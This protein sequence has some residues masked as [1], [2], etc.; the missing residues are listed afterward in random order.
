MDKQKVQV[1]ICGKQYV[2][3]TD[4]TP[5]HVRRVANY[6]DRIL[7]DTVA[8]TRLTDAQA[9]VLAAVTLAEEVLQCRDENARL[10]RE[11][12]AAQEKLEGLTQA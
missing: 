5:E 6:A 3:S 9:Y 12:R 2:L 4:D 8:A 7:R 1:I 11:L 10:R